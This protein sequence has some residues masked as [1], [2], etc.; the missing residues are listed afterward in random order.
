MA[1]VL[2]F[3]ILSAAKDLALLPK[4][5]FGV[6]ARSFASPRMT[7]LAC[8]SPVSAPARRCIGTTRAGSAARP[9]SD[10]PSASGRLA[11]SLHV[12]SLPPAGEIRTVATQ[13]VEQ[14]DEGGVA[15]PQVMR[16][17]E[18]CDH[19]PGLVGPALAEQAAARRRGQHGDQRVAVLV[20]HAAE[21]EDLLGRLF[22]GAANSAIFR[23]RRNGSR[24]ETRGLIPATRRRRTPGLRREEGGRRT[25]RAS[26]ST[27][28]R[29]RPGTGSQR[30]PVPHHLSTALVASRAALGKAE[31][32]D[33]SAPLARQVDG[34]ALRKG[35]RCPTSIRHLVEELASIRS[36]MCLHSAGPSL[37]LAGPGTRRP[38][39]SSPSAAC[40]RRSA[41]RC[42]PC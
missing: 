18:H 2:S 22:P 27:G 4:T 29:A 11:T 33:L 23:R 15:C 5:L 7:G 39:R 42:S 37:G 25:R 14:V 9:S 13:P 12:V 6:G 36:V 21:G 30:Q 40:P 34:R 3:V 38:R 16:H 35:G 26:A 32:N 10:G 24:P 31:H 41:T 17:A 1:P 28:H 8:R 19:P 20:G